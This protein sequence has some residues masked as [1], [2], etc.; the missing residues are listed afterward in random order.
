MIPSKTELH[1][2]KGSP[3]RTLDESPG[4]TPMWRPCGRHMIAAGVCDLSGLC[5]RWKGSKVP[6]AWRP[7]NFTWH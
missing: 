7:A 3:Q 5:L 1:K 6:P 4:V 2:S